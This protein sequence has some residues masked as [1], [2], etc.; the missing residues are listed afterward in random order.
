MTPEH[1][2]EVLDFIGEVLD[3]RAWR[4]DEAGTWNTF[5]EVPDI[6]RL[7]GSFHRYELKPKPRML[8]LWCQYDQPGGALVVRET[9][10]DSILFNKNWVRVGQPFPHPD[11]V[12]QTP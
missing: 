5:P 9:S 8:Q 10:D 6:R 3:G 12:E 1:K 11:D 4:Y 7:A 2:R